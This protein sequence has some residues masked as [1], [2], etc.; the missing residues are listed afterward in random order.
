MWERADSL[1]SFDSTFNGETTKTMHVRGYQNLLIDVSKN[2]ISLNASIQAEEDLA[3]KT[4]DSLDA[5]NYRFYNLYIKGTNLF[6]ALDFKL[7][8]HYM[9]AGVGKGS[10]DG[11]SFK[12]KAGK[13]KQIQLT[14]YGGILTP[15]DYNFKNYGKLK[16]NFLA[17]AMFTY[18]GIDGL[19]ASL[20]YARKHRKPQ[21]Y[22]YIRID[23]LF[24]SQ[25]YFLDLDSRSDQSAGLDLTYDHQN[26]GRLFGYIK[27]YFDINDNFKA[28][29]IEADA[30]IKPIDKLTTFIRYMYYEPKISFN[31]IFWVFTH[32]E[33]HEIE[34]GFD[35]NIF[36]DISAFVRASYVMYNGD[37]P[38]IATSSPIPS[39][40]SVRLEAGFNSPK[41]G[42]QYTRYFG[43]AGQSD[44]V[45]GYYYRQ[46]VKSLSAHL[47]LSYSNYRL[48]DFETTTNGTNEKIDALAG[49][50]GFTFRPFKNL[51]VDVQG[52]Y[53]FNEIYKSDVRLLA[54][55][56]LWF[57]KNFNR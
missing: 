24:N 29:R 34:G 30:R 18:Y 2:K 7:G 16:E 51:S 54:G 57:F 48:E 45:N 27:A 39:D 26:L 33:N 47:S 15:L 52:Q 8:R 50:L 31:S 21:S 55:V 5:F 3:G 28:Q 11:L 56:N 41:Y 25:S 4:N 9:Y 49:M 43:Y 46:I 6:N 32:K 53:I 38:V 10:I 17:G 19:T 1:M 20:S 22:S 14:A 35:Y 12:I 44:A 36:R 37:A 13:N 42:M 40:N 23:S